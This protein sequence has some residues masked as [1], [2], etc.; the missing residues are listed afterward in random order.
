MR[1]KLKQ[2]PAAGETREKK[3]FAWFPIKVGS[4][5]IFLEH[6]YISQVYCK[7]FG[8]YDTDGPRLADYYC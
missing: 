1:W 3:V 2:E 6:Y 8:W 7:G 5:I 4:H